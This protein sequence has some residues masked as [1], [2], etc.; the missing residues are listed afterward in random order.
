MKEKADRFTDAFLDDRRMDDY[1]EAVRTGKNLYGQTTSQK[2]IGHSSMASYNIF[3]D[4]FYS[5]VSGMDA[6]TMVKNAHV[7]N[8]LETVWANRT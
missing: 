6:A 3:V 2:V 7:K 4:N 5:A 1:Y 8:Y